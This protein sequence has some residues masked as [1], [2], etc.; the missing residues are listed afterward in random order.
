[1]PAEERVVLFRPRTVLSVLGVALLFALTLALVYLAWRVITW[2][3]IAVFLAAALNPAVEFLERRGLR[4]GF[5][6]AA[7]FLAALG[8]IAVLASLLVPPLV[9]QVRKFVDAVPDIVADITAGRGPLGFLEEDYGIV[10]RVRKAIEEQGAGGVLGATAPALAVA[11]G[12]VTAI[13]G[14]VT[15]AFLTLFMLLE[16]PQLVRRLLGLLQP[17]TRERWERVG[18]NV[19]RTIGGYVTGNLAISLIAGVTST[20]FLFVL[21]SDYAVA[22]GLVVALLDLIPLAGATIAAVVVSGVVFAELGWVKGVIAVVFFLLYQ[23]LENHVLQPVIYGRT[24]QLSPLVVLVAVLIGA[25]LAGVLGALAA[26]PLA[27]SLQAIGRE[28]LVRRS[29]AAGAV[30]ARASP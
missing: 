5:A 21:G 7:V 26:I 16:G 17:R 22:L 9:E 24:V 27:G 30:P 19:Y 28:V 10:E 14:T 29:D 4:R 20:I 3:L 8:A 12:V 23:Q 6:A 25:E 18:E 2:V 15:I 1:M 13:V 11:H